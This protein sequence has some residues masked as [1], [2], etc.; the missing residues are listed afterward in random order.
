VSPAEWSLYD[1]RAHAEARLALRSPL[2][3]RPVSCGGTSAAGHASCNGCTA[4]GD[5]LWLEYEATAAAGGERASDSGSGSWGG[6]ADDDGAAPEQ[7]LS[8]VPLRYW[9]FTPELQWQSRGEMAFLTGVAITTAEPGLG[10]PL[11]PECDQRCLHA[12]GRWQRGVAH[13]HFRTR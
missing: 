8:E 4:G 7:L 5:A 9:L 13:I 3:L 2:R 10:G 6:Q 1:L 11:A 12:A